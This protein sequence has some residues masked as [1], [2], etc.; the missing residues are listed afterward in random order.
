MPKDDKV[1]NNANVINVGV[2]LEGTGGTQFSLEELKHFDPDVVKRAFKQAEAEGLAAGDRTARTY[3]LI[4]QYTAAQNKPEMINKMKKGSKTSAKQNKPVTKPAPTQVP[5]EV[6]MSKYDLKEPPVSTFETQNQTLASLV[7]T[8][9]MLAAKLEAAD[10]PEFVETVPTDFSC[11]QIPDLAAEAGRPKF[12]V[13]FDLGRLGKQEV[14]YHWVIE[15]NGCLALVYD[16]RFEFGMRY[17]PPDNGKTPITVKLPDH[18]KEYSAISMDFS[19]PFGVFFITNLIL[20]SNTKTDS[21]AGPEHTAVDSFQPGMP[22][23]ELVRLVSA[24]NDLPFSEQ[25]DDYGE[26][27]RD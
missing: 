16:T 11:L 21:N 3:E 15:H 13:Q 1:T 2:S 14:W 4:R 5:I 6:D 9:N 17:S 20:V 18:G 25:Q 10:E 12:R 23:N 27:W 8:V 19:L 24:S 7:D 26:E 22:M